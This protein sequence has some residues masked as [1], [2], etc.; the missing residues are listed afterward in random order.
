MSDVTLSA[1]RSLL[2]VLQL[3]LHCMISSYL[4]YADWNDSNPSEQIIIFKP[5]VERLKT[6]LQ[7]Q[8]HEMMLPFTA[9]PLTLVWGELWVYLFVVCWV[10]RIAV[11]FAAGFGGGIPPVCVIVD[12]TALKLQD[13]REKTTERIS[14]RRLPRLWRLS[15]SSAPSSSRTDPWSSSAWHHSSPSSGLFPAVLGSEGEISRS[16]VKKRGRKP[17]LQ[18]L[19]T[20]PHLPFIPEHQAGGS[21]LHQH[22]QEEN[23][24]ELRTEKIACWSWDPLQIWPAGAKMV[25]SVAFYVWPRPYRGEI[26]WFSLYMFLWIMIVAFRWTQVKDWF[27]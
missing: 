4:N 3:I 18:R 12:S 9:R 10:E 20:Q 15:P 17:A 2:Q 25:S 14:R 26:L 23:Q 6:S 19:L 11:F 27:I 16:D 24:E 22:Q 13:F 1:A 7:T 21:Q 8:N 5:F